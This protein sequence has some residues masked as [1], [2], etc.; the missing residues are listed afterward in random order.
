MHSQNTSTEPNPP[1][2]FLY[3]TTFHRPAPMDDDAPVIVHS[4]LDATQV[5]PFL[6]TIYPDEGLHALNTVLQTPKEF[7]AVAINLRHGGVL[8]FQVLPVKVAKEL[9]P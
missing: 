9:T 3:L 6:S 7:F 1:T 8:V 4:G 5:V 2:Q